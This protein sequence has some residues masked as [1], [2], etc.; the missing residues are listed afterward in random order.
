MEDN[1]N[2]NQKS[3]LDVLG[4]TT[5][6]IGKM[7]IKKFVTTKVLLIVAVVIIVAIIIVAA[8]YYV[9]TNIGILD[10][11]R[12]SNVPNKVDQYTNGYVVQ[13]DGTTVK[14]ESIQELWDELLEQD[15]E[16]T[17]YLSTPEELAKLVNA[18]SVT[19]NLDLRP[20][21]E[22]EDPDQVE[23]WKKVYD[24]NSTETLGI[25]KLKRANAT[26][27]NTTMEYV[28]PQK[29]DN[30]ISTYESNGSNKEEVELHFTLG[31]THT[32]EGLVKSENGKLLN[33]VSDTAIVRYTNSQ[34]STSTMVDGKVIA[35]GNVY[36]A[37]TIIFIETP[38]DHASNGKFFYIE[39]VIPSDTENIIEVYTSNSGNLRDDK[40]G[41]MESSKVFTL[42][43][44]E[45]QTWGQYQTEY[46]SYD[47]EEETTEDTEEVDPNKVYD[48]PDDYPEMIWPAVSSVITSEYQDAREDPTKPGYGQIKPHH[49]ID[50]GHITATDPIVA[51]ADGVVTVAV[52]GQVH[53]TSGNSYGNYVKIRHDNGLE[54]LYSHLS[55]V[56]VTVGQEVSAGQQIGIIGMTGNST[57]IHLHFEM[58]INGTKVN[59]ILFDY[60]I[61]R[62]GGETQVYAIVATPIRHEHYDDDG[63]L[64]YTYSV[65]VNNIDYR[66]MVEQ[67][68]LPFEF[69]WA[70]LTVSDDKSFVMGIADLV[71]GSEIEI[72]IADTYKGRTETETV[73]TR[74][75]MLY[76]T[77]V[78]IGYPSTSGKENLIDATIEYVETGEEE[79]KP[80]TA[81]SEETLTLKIFL[82]KANTWLVDMNLEYT[83]QEDRGAGSYSIDDKEGYESKVTLTYDNGE[84][85][86]DLV[87]EAEK[88]SEIAVGQIHPIE[89]SENQTLIDLYNSDVE[90]DFNPSIGKAVEKKIKATDIKILTEIY[91]ASTVFW[92]DD[93]EP[94]YKVDRQADKEPDEIEPNFV[95]L[96]HDIE[97]ADFRSAVFGAEEWL[98]EI[99]EKNEDTANM[100]DIM[101]YL[102]YEATNQD[103]G[104]TEEDMDV[105]IWHADE[106]APAEE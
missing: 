28:D 92:V 93:A 11:D 40:Y 24:V 65:E 102:L 42:N 15:S 96:Y 69:L 54:S 51:T 68:T 61:G 2:D 22:M 73:T 38:E 16:I 53:D 8:A 76:E 67:F 32:T 75:D 47:A 72:T 49:A 36:T 48:S 41:T 1:G 44:S 105:D 7:L 90:N 52:T 46:Q 83:L 85:E 86:L 6:L 14:P 56:N 33:V 101:R 88:R 97:S 78:D 63:K 10:S 21:S 58:I 12:D 94:E 37:G 39:E 59:P 29:F 18:E 98:F 4:D 87:A 89:L 27:E 74:E 9:I 60:D 20:L 82:S 35:T 34:N 70:L 13:E 26:G 81:E 71:Y 106:F 17:H 19:Q 77:N 80:P 99:L 91:T 95:T 64:Y 57:G 45:V 43:S 104:V 79:E 25:V 55:D 50:I 84:K 23:F 62:F 3:F 100:V 103:F 5:K 30:I 66:S 31:V